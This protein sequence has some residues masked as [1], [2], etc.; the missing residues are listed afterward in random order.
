MPLTEYPTLPSGREGLSQLHILFTVR[1][2]RPYNLLWSKLSNARLWHTPV[3]HDIKCASKM[4]SFI[5]AYLTGIFTR[6]IQ[7]DS[8]SILRLILT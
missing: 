3:G 4:R 7:L 2:M 8:L 1:K 6:V 5:T